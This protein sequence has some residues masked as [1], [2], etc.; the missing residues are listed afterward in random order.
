MQANGEPVKEM[1]LRRKDYIFRNPKK[2]YFKRT[3]FVVLLLA[4]VG[5]SWFWMDASI[6]ESL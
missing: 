4:L 6:F 2:S 5:F 1:K 3:V